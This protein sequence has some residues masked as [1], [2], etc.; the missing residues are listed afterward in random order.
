MCA[1]WHRVAHAPGTVHLHMHLR[2]TVTYT[3]RNV[4]VRIECHVQAGVRVG[5]Q[6]LGILFTTDVAEGVPPFQDEV[7]IPA[8]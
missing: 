2:L 5:C 3:Q 4:P 1:T 7:G 6:V 8:V